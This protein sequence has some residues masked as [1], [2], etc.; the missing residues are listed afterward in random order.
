MDRITRETVKKEIEDVSS[1]INQ[2]DVTDINRTFPEQKQNIHS[3]L[4]H[5]EHSPGKTIC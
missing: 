1:P 5:R 4:V 3:F 2:L